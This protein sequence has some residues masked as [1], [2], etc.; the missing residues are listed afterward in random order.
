FKTLGVKLEDYQIEYTNTIIYTH[1]LNCKAAVRS[2][3][4]MNCQ[5]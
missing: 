1:K 4:K 2:G 5:V 3:V